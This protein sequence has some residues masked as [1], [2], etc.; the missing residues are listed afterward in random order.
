VETNNPSSAKH[1]RHSA[2]AKRLGLSDR[3]LFQFSVRCSELRSLLDSK[4]LRNLDV[5]IVEE[6][7]MVRE[8]EVHFD[9]TPTLCIFVWISFPVSKTIC[10][11]L[12]LHFCSCV[13]LLREEVVQR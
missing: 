13:V 7:L 10:L 8:L 2:G 3:V 9:M 4:A 5:P 11:R 12:A 6:F 1:R